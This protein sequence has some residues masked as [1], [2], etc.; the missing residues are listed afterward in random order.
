MP[1]PTTP[2]AEAAA[3]VPPDS[4]VGQR[5]RLRQ[6]TAGSPMVESIGI[7]QDLTPDSIRLDRDRGVRT[8]ALSPTVRL[9]I[10]R[11]VRAN[12]GRGAWIGALIGG[13]GMGTLGALSCDGRGNIVSFSSSDC[14]KGG[15]LLGGAAGALL[16]LGIGAL[17]RTERWEE[18]HP[19]PG[20]VFGPVDRQAP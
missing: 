17:V 4:I 15:A 7:V 14:A 12:T 8:A 16:G 18:V 10:S 6:A 9:E 1:S 11:G 13:L 19:D 20:I 3:Q 2:S 5:A